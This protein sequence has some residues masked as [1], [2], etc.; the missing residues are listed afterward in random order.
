MPTV[1][2]AVALVV[3]VVLAGCG[4]LLG[5]GG[6]AEST[7]T[8]TLTPAPVPEPTTTV[9]TTDRPGTPTAERVTATASSG[10]AGPSNGGDRQ[11]RYF[12]LNP[13]CERPP[14]L[15][16][17]IQVA[18]LANDDGTGEGIDAT[19][20]FASP[21]NRRQ[22]GSY[23]EFVDLITRRYRPLL[24]AERITYSSLERTGRNATRRVTVRT[25]G[26]SDATYVWIVQR[27]TGGRYEGC[28]M[29]A[30]VVGPI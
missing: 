22:I 5:A 10:P 28:W 13:T 14:G 15:V 19:W 2:T 4:A 7:P 27:Q 16:V 8:P 25:A 12:G 3:V 29:T 6:S 26:G 30:G 24:D 21:S 9:T 17:H 1:R 18:A 23:E 20:R 11:P